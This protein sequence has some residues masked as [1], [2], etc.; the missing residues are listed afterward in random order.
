MLLDFESGGRDDS[1]ENKNKNKNK[2]KPNTNPYS[3]AQTPA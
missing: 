3:Q 2:N 1:S